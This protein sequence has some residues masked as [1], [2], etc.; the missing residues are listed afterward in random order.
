MAKY[1]KNG[2]ITELEKDE[3]FVFGS[4]GQGAHLGGAAATAVHK[5]GAKMGQAEGLQGQSYA[6]NTMDGDEEMVAQIKRFLKFAKE[7]PEL[8]FLVTEIGCGIAGYS[9]E[10]IAPKFAK[11]SKNVILPDSFNE[12]LS[13][14]S[15]SSPFKDR[16][17]GMLVGLAV[18]DALGAPFQFGNSSY[19]IEDNINDL[20]HMHENHVLPKG[21][22]TDDTSMALC[23]ADSLLEQDGYHSYDVMNKYCDW[24]DTGYRSYFPMGYDEGAQVANALSRYRRNPIIPKDTEKEWNAGNGAIMRLAP[25][26]IANTSPRK[27]YNEKR[28]TESELKPIE[29]MAILSCR[30]THNS[31]AAECVTGMFSTVL[32]AAIRGFSKPD[33]CA[34]AE[35]GTYLDS[36]PLADEYDKF[37]L[38]NVDLLIN[39]WRKK[40]ADDLRDL[41][42]YIVDAYAIAMWGFTNSNSFEDGMK[43]VLCLGGDT[44][45]NA[46]IYGQVAGAYYGY[47]AIPEEWKKDVYL[48][49]E[50]VKIADELLDLK[51]CPII[52]TR[53]EDDEHF[54][55]LSNLS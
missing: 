13:A 24:E 42:G 54:M 44:D 49:E 46:A 51:E 5:F 41:G 27:N 32:F 15:K 7:H 37:W 25:I 26:I 21:V 29:E 6:I 10:Q 35:R 33:I 8:A 48:S 52:A 18:G 53:F 55:A 31:I 14:K 22:W 36:L 12:A 43:M 4:N 38:E 28:I 11:H 50:L 1:D 2:Y 20:M 9:P 30:E 3:V 17:R 40:N 34:Y 16:A 47:D 19:A 45:T 23:I 39:R